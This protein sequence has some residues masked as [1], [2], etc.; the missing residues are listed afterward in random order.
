MDVMTEKI[1]TIDP[2]FFIRFADASDTPLILSFIKALAEYE[3]MLD[4]VVAT[5]EG[6]AKSIFEEGHAEVIIG[7]YDG[8][9]VGF[10]LFFHN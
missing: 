8:E 10:A 9:P 3:D 4:L 1:A 5:P 2:R 6:L 7:E